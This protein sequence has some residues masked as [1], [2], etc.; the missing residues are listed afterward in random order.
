MIKNKKGQA[1]QFIGMIFLG[2]AFVM[3]FIAIPFLNEFITIGAETSGTAT[4]FVVRAIPWV[5]LIFMVVYGLKLII[6]G[7]SSE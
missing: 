7:G 4:S 1:A 5:I 3:F 6:F 2:M